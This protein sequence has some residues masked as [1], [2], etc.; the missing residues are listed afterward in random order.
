ME[1]NLSTVAADKAPDWNTLLGKMGPGSAQMHVWILLQYRASSH[2]LVPL[3]KMKEE[4]AQ[5]ERRRR[6]RDKNNHI[7]IP[8]KSYRPYT[9]LPVSG[10]SLSR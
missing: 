3:R 5:A 8:N 4:E 10:L 1:L 9:L 2:L 7:L 6:E